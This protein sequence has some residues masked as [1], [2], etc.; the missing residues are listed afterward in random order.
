[1]RQ[2]GTDS[3]GNAFSDEIKIQVWRKTG[4]SKSFLSKLLPENDKASGSKP[5]A[6]LSKVIQKAGV[7]QSTV[8]GSLT[9]LLDSVKD[10]APASTGGL[11]GKIRD[12]VHEETPDVEERRVDRYGNEM[13][14]G[15]YGNEQSEL[16]WEIDHIQ[17]VAEG[18]LDMLSNLQPLQWKKNREKG[19]QF[20]FAG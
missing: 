15:D 12:F 16:G 19:D 5:L 2:P 18:G 11:L 1:M 13:R 8:R 10:K 17:P 20:P 7:A 6:L 9:G 3:S 4:L 14:F